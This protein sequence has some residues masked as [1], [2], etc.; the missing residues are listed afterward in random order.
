MQKFVPYLFVL[1]LAAGIAACGG[2]TSTTAA[3]PIYAELPAPLA[4][5]NTLMGGAVQG[6]AIS[7]KFSNYSVSTFTGVAGSAGFSDYSTT[8]GPPARFNQLNDITTDGINFYV[9][10]FA[11]NVIRKVT[12]L[13]EV[14]TIS[15]PVT[16]FPVGVNRPSGITTD[17]T[18]LYVVAYGSN[19]INIID[20]ASGAVTTI[21]STT[22]LA[23]SVDVKVVAPATAADATLARFNQPTGITTDGV[24][25][26]VT[27]SGN[28][29]VR[30]IE[31]ATKAVSTVAGTSGIAG[32]T[33][34]IQGVARFNIPN[35]ITTD[36]T[37][38]F[39]T[40]FGNRTIRK[41]DIASGLVTTLAG[42][43]GP[44]GKDNGTADSTDGT[45]AT[46]RFYHPNGITTD[47]TN[48]YVTDSYQNTIRKADKV[49]GKVVT[50]AGIPGTPQAA[51]GA[52]DSPGIPSFSG[53]IGITTDGASLFV[54]DTRNHTIRKI[55]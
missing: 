1:L 38:L 49:S 18:N 26:Y 32:S 4:P 54:A 11:K 14:R 53:P 48:L 24:Y 10:D 51:G 44:L 31:I 8:N 20:I 33:N 45:G 34:G 21:G 42:A 7:A 27:D 15:N 36:G 19:T 35:R 23:G 16:G 39:L 5:A 12:P 6:G 46:A 37:S 41:I 3:T 47:G 30:R 43:P 29:T 13:G 9:A 22:G 28:H 50:I 52:V 2:S 55:K 40:D 17:G 25:L